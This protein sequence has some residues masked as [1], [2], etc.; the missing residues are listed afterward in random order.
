V[1][2]DEDMFGTSLVE[3]L[4]GTSD[5]E[6]DLL[7]GE[8]GLHQCLLQLLLFSSCFGVTVNCRV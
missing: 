7:S 6:M 1:F 8:G 4:L 5:E 2:R 3:E